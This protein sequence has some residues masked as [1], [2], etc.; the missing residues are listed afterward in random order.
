MIFGSQALTWG[1]TGAW[2][3]T[4][5]VCATEAGAPPRHQKAIVAADFD[6]TVRTLIYTGRPLR[7]IKNEY[8]MDWYGSLF[9]L[10]TAWFEISF[11]AGMRIAGRR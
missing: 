7:V 1:A 11:F 4:R 10:L 3:G 5:F 2:V 8:I 9:L 6:S